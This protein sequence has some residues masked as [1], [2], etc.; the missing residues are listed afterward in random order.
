MAD[1]ETDC[2]ENATVKKAPADVV[3]DLFDSYCLLINKLP[4]RAE[5][6]TAI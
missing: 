3:N 1:N 2:R 6:N 4:A 5:Q